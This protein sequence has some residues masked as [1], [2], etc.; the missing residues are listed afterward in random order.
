MKALLV[1]FVLLLA[2]LTYAGTPAANPADGR[3]ACFDFQEQLWRGGSLNDP[4]DAASA[5]LCDSYLD[6]IYNFYQ[7]YTAR[8]APLQNEILKTAQDFES[9]GYAQGAAFYRGF[10][11]ENMEL[12]SIRLLRKENIESPNFELPSDP[13]KDE[14]LKSVSLQKVVN[15]SLQEIT[16][17]KSVMADIHANKKRSYE[18]EI[19]FKKIESALVRTDAVYRLATEKWDLVTARLTQVHFLRLLQLDS[20][21]LVKYT[22][23]MEDII[24]GTTPKAE[25]Q[26]DL[27]KD[28][29]LTE[30]I[31][32]RNATL[33]C[34]WER[35][36][37][38]ENYTWDDASMRHELNPNSRLAKFSPIVQ[39]QTDGRK[40]LL[41]SAQII[42]DDTCDYDKSTKG[43]KCV[44]PD[45]EYRLA[46]ENLEEIDATLLKIATLYKARFK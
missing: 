2:S 31:F 40:V 33:E 41:T 25:L 19:G 18:L 45:D 3:A 1:S 4:K 9:K 30:N 23:S 37:T 34:R 32:S 6:Q 7:S 13:F 15:D 44:R 8:I 46:G 5:V 11:K 24:S 28:R 39:V 29:P 16:A 38:S 26:V 21:C 17:M 22:K 42:T 35:F 14:D 43:N 10:V 36:T 12:R 20:S 27:I